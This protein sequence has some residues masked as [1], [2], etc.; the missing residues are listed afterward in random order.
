M[1][2]AGVVQRASAM[3]SRFSDSEVWRAL[4]VWVM[5]WVEV[6]PPRRRVVRMPRA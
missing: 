6:V 3:V 4:R 5:G 2:A 1:R